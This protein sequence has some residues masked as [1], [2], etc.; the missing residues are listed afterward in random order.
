MHK[1]RLIGKKG[2]GTFS[3]VLKAQ[4]I[5]NSKYVAIKCMKNHFD[6]LEQVN[7]LREIQALRR[8][9]PHPGVIK[10]CEVLYDQPT[11][12]LALVF[13]LMD[14]NIYELI[15]GRRHYLPE[16]R[17]K[18]Y[19]YQLLKSMDHMHRNG[20][21][22]RDIKPEN[23]LITDDELKLADF[24]SCRGIYSK[25]PYTE[26]IST[27]W[28]R[29]PECLLTDGF[30]NY[31]M[32]LWGVGCVFFEV[33]S[34]Y[35][36]FPGTN[37]LDQVTKIHQILGTPTPEVL[38]KLK[39]HSNSH[40]DFNFGHKDP[41]QMSKLIPH[42]APECVD[43]IVKLLAYDPDDR[44][45]ARQAVKHSYFKEQR[46]AEAK[47]KAAQGQAIEGEGS[48]DPL[49][50]AG[51]GGSAVGG[52]KKETSSMLP[53]I[54][55]GKHRHSDEGGG[56]ADGFAEGAP[57]SNPLQPGQEHAQNDAGSS[58][59]PPIGGFGT[60][61]HGQ[62]GV[63]TLKIDSKSLMAGGKGKAA[64]QTQK[65]TGGSMPIG[66]K[67][68]IKPRAGGTLALGAAAPS[69]GGAVVGRT[70]QMGEGAPDLGVGNSSQHA[71][72]SQISEPESLGAVGGKSLQPAA[73]APQG[74]KSY[75]SPYSQRFASP[76][77]V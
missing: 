37:E 19:M 27:R 52:K 29:A 21:F 38:A 14:M 59:L 56:D 47:E 46:A 8:L 73:K 16:S 31:T 51:V 55:G 5:K 9:S 23:I 41:Q 34:L 26:Y 28:Y 10:L 39:K 70:Y 11:R 20:I 60:I 74:G 36:L 63:S 48:G 42:C 54:G 68:A 67:T 53:S 66:G 17:I 50:Q 22:H 71:S 65:R 58:M 13:E 77:K 45:S 6:S 33:F 18:S 35:P 49:P 76:A 32:D 2:E 30:Y 3:E 40:I 61:A 15:R 72:Q 64:M 69:H 62:S 1:Y 25:Q 24:G 44:L 7:N 12:R 57:S 4:S 75:C 43:I